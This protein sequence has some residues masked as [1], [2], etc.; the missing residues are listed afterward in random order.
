MRDESE[1]D[2]ATRSQV[3]WI[4]ELPLGLLSCACWVDCLPFKQDWSVK[5]E[6]SDQVWKNEEAQWPGRVSMT[7]TEG[8]EINQAGGIQ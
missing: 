5:L 8:G 4:G 7:W 6:S 3:V 2:K 1:E